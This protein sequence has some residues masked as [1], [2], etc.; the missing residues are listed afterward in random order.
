[1]RDHQVG[2]IVIIDSL[3]NPIGIVTDTDIRNKVVAEN[4]STGNL[5]ETIMTSPVVTASPSISLSEAMMEMIRSGVHHLVI[6]KDGSANT[7][8]C[9]MV[10]D[11]DVMVSQKNHPASLIK[12]IKRS[13][14][15]E[16]WH[17]IRDDAEDLMQSYLQQGMNIQLIAGTITKINDTII[18]KSVDLA[19]EETGGL[20]NIAFCWLNLGSEGRE[21]QLPAHRPRQCNPFF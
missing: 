8:T 9:G 13:N 7:S 4:Q 11:H 17:K 20:E 6:T 19:I 3:A 2:S 10:S 21:E 16:Q 14:K 15:P 1:M 18:Q 5:I 12:S